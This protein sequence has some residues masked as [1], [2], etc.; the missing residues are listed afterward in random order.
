MRDVTAVGIDLGTTYSCIAYLNE[1]GEPVTI[2]NDE[3][4][5]S[6]PSV[7]LFDG[8]EV[9][10]GTEALRHAIVEPDYVVQNSKR[11]MGDRNKVW[12]IDD[13]TFT[14]TDIA[15]F[16]VKKL[17]F[18]AR[19]TLGPI[20][21]AVITVPAQFTDAQR[22]ATTEA[23]LRAGLDQVDIINEPIAAA[24]CYVLGSE[25]LWF[26]ELADKQTVLVYDLGGGTFDLSLVSYS[27]NNVEVIASGGELRLG[28]IDWNLELQN[29][30][31]DQ[32]LREF[33]CD[34]AENAESLQA[35][36]IE[37]EHA[38]R[39]L[40]VRPRT[41]LVCQH[42]GHRKAYRVEQAQFE[43]LTRPLVQRTRDIT[44]A[45]LK[46]NSMGWAH[47]DA[48]LTT[49]GASRMPMVRDML[50]RLSGTTLNTSLSPDQSI[51]HG[52]TYY[53]G[54]LLTNDDYARSILTDKAARRLAQVKHTAVNARS[55]GILVRDV[56]GRTR[57][58]HYLIPA[59]TPLPTSV[60]QT[61]GTV[62]PG[63]QRVSLPLVESDPSDAAKYERVGEC[64]IEN[65]PPDLPK[66][67]AIAVTI[68]YDE[69]ARVHVEATDVT[70]GAKAVAVLHRGEIPA[71][72]ARP[73]PNEEVAPWAADL[74][75]GKKAAADAEPARREPSKPRQQ[76]A[77]TKP[78]ATKPPVS[79]PKVRTTKN[80]DPL[81]SAETPIPLCNQCGEPLDLTAGQCRK[82]EQAI[83]TAGERLTTRRPAPGAAKR[84][85]AVISDRSAG[86]PSGSRPPQ[87]AQK[88][89]SQRP[90]TQTEQKKP[91]P[92]DEFWKLVE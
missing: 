6:T 10:V 44:T 82:C 36:A 2:P 24:L 15:T 68:R 54:M 12:K 39:S 49:G 32:F 11:F 40:S 72:E 56:D 76:P 31:A 74:L 17:L 70:G 1:H 4:E 30:I 61:Y 34:P 14:P 45:L 35:L 92:E 91:S 13:R 78:P 42:A 65:L 26:S 51:A 89:A 23:G 83:P 63:Q 48:V 8:S 21:R 71:D 88:G 43:K 38:K 58:P 80:I 66:M 20:H 60:T 41:P 50:K 77:A 84:T 73:D 55:L 75:D 69:Q 87:R 29:A 79:M 47:V 18:A 53:A 9:V 5:L 62:L 59:N 46:D 19:E 67:S 3:G 27:K 33:G 7:V 64:V 52:A 57:L 86:S 81:E 37:V 85:T 16:I 28:G 22:Q 25:G 90:A